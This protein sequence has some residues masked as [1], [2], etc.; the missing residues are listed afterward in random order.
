MAEL[1]TIGHNKSP[2]H[3]TTELIQDLFDEAKNW[4]DGEPLETKEQHD[5]LVQLVKDIRA[6]KREAD[7]ARKEEAKPFD[8]AKAEIQERYNH[9]IKAKTG[10]A[11]MAVETAQQVLAPYLAEQQR[12]KDE[13][14]REATQKALEA[15]RKALEAMEASKG[16]LE[17]RQEAEKLVVERKKAEAEHHKIVNTNIAKGARTVWDV[18]VVNSIAAVQALWSTHQARFEELLID[19]A[20]SEVRAGKRSIEGFEITSRK[21][22]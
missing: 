20:Q 15:E 5:A 11:D 7:T 16:D 12:I 13:A 21:V 3:L 2:F 8:E 1:A 4:L 9:F 14:E 10:L 18:K 22:I 6:A 19:I 17:A